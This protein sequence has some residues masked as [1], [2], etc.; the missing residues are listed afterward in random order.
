[1]TYNSYLTISLCLILFSCGLTPRKI[2]FN[3]KELK[4][5]WAAAEKAD[6]IAFGFSEIEKDSKIS[7]EE[8]SIFENPYDKMLHIYGTTSRTIAFESPEKG[9]LKWIGEQEI[10]SGPKRY[11]TPDGEFNEQIVL[12]YELT[13]ISGH[14]INELNI[15]Y[16]GERSELTGN[17]N[18][19]LEIVRPY[20]KAWVEKE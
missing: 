8:N 9:G 19:T 15:S 14:K 5:Y 4:P 16:N 20:I 6:R 13:P 7:L 18:L 1:M 17:N 2:D 10:Y 12:T 11:Q 3:D